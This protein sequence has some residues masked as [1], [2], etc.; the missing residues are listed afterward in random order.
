M[1]KLIWMGHQYS[2]RHTRER[3]A[4]APH[5]YCFSRKL[6]RNAALIIPGSQVPARLLGLRIVVAS[7]QED[8]L[9]MPGRSCKSILATNCSVGESIAKVA[10]ES[11]TS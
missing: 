6:L 9:R 10:R 8:V 1:G 7:Q 5:K 3:F 11:R 2:K 4:M